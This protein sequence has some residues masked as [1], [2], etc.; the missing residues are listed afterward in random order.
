MKYFDEAAN[1]GTTSEQTQK[2]PPV[3]AGTAVL[4]PT[5]EQL[6]AIGKLLHDVKDV[7]KR[8]EDQNKTKDEVEAEAMRLLNSA[9]K[10]QAETPRKMVFPSGQSG[11]LRQLCAGRTVEEV[12]NLPTDN[13]QIRE[14]Q[15]LGS[16]LAIQHLIHGSPQRAHRTNYYE[17]GGY[18]TLKAH[19]RFL[20][21]SKELDKAVRA[22]DS[23]KPWNI[24]TAGQGLEFVPSDLA[25]TWLEPY[26]LKLAVAALFREIP[27][28]TNPFDIPVL[29]TRVQALKRTE[30]AAKPTSVY[31]EITLTNQGTSKR[32][33]TAVGYYMVSM[34]SSY[35]E[36]DAIDAVMD[37]IRDDLGRGMVDALE[38]GIL[39]GDTAGTHQD[40]DVTA[41]TDIRTCWL[42]LRAYCADM[43]AAG[44]NGTS[45][46]NGNMSVAG[47][48][49]ARAAIGKFGVIPQECA[50]I[51]SPMSY[52]KLIKD[53]NVA[54]VDKFGP[55]AT[56]LQGELAK[57]EGIPIIVSEWQREDIDN[58]GYYVDGVDDVSAAI[59]VNRMAGFWGT[60]GG[61][62][63]ET[64]HDPLNKADTLIADARRAWTWHED[65]AAASSKYIHC[66]IKV[67]LA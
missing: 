59:L 40:A 63:L 53:T 48:Q 28:P 64:F 17:R 23:T 51:I 10:T 31:S 57:C 67:T 50:C 46:L 13:K 16:R 52:L 47:L 32:T 20:S 41:A 21:L 60:K 66:L 24:T 34:I 65:A 27:M 33:L 11:E 14:W 58:E 15:E 25:N 18:R 26:R 61:I 5:T 7:L 1:G 56:I 35:A 42:G 30:V 49:A 12:Y 6:H 4:D 29:T 45:V 22:A 62:A 9:I 36:E 19:Q 37:L 2:K 44:N 39:N 3:E 54:T 55:A 38:N 43:E 8:G